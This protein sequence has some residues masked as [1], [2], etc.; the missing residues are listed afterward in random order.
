MAYRQTWRGIAVL[1]GQLHVVFAHDRL[2]FAGS[3]ALPG[4]HAAVA[5]SKAITSRAAAWLATETGA[6]V[7]IRRTGERVV[8]P[9][10]HG[11]GD[12]EYH[13]ADV[14]DATSTGA[15][16]RWDVY[17]DAEGAPLLR[18]SRLHFATGQL[19]L[20]AGDRGPGGTR[21]DVGAWRAEV[22]AVGV[23]TTTDDAG[24]FTWAGAG[25]ATVVPSFLGDL[26]HIVAEAGAP[27]TASLTAA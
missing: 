26:I 6:T 19:V 21:H 3:E 8:V 2:F 4:V 27:A 17:V 16:G 20:D 12:I 9:F 10:V 24:N 1:G 25:A 15:P 13:V 22:T 14:L 18:V 23:A 5:A 7:A 11:T